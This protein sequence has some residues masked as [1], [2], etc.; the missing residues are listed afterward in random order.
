MNPKLKRIKELRNKLHQFDNPSDVFIKA[1]KKECENEG[2]DSYLVSCSEQDFE[3]VIK[4]GN[5]DN[6]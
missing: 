4:K 1:I 5:I 6:F 3:T 2:I